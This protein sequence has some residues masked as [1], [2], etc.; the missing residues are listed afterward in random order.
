MSSNS[1]QVGRTVNFLSTHAIMEQKKV[2]PCTTSCS[3]MTM[4]TSKREKKATRTYLW[5]RGFPDRRSKTASQEPTK[6]V[7]LTHQRSSSVSIQPINGDGASADLEQDPNNVGRVQPRSDSERCN[8]V[9]GVFGCV[10]R[11]QRYVGVLDEYSNCV[12]S[13]LRHERRVRRVRCSTTL[14]EHPRYELH[15]SDVSE[16]EKT[17]RTFRLQ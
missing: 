7:R 5:N 8:A 12:Q 4:V 1:R 9:H 11:V 16:E 2:V 15:C 6:K 10:Q 14:V 3:L 17:R 13:A